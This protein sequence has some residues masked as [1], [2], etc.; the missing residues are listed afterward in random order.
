MLGSFTESYALVH[1]EL[2]GPNYREARIHLQ[3]L[4]VGRAAGIARREKFEA[5][6]VRMLFAKGSLV[7]RVLA[8][9]MMQGDWS[10]ADVSTITAAIADGRS[11]NEQYHGLQLAKLCWP[12]LSTSDRQEI[13]RAIGRTDLRANSDRSR[14]A[15]AELSL[16]TS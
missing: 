1:D 13:H 4:L 3:D 14:K 6:E 7:M 12:R 11:R 16:P 5:R 9:G 10:L 8:L 15:Q 2:I